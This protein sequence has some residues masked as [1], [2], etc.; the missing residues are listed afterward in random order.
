MVRHAFLGSVKEGNFGPMREWMWTELWSSF[1]GPY[2]MGR[3]WSKLLNQTSGVNNTNQREEQTAFLVSY[4]SYNFYLVFLSAE[5]S[6]LF[7]N[8]FGLGEFHIIVLRTNIF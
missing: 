4:F 6:N 7:S 2:H 1:L 3:F 5:N 8:F